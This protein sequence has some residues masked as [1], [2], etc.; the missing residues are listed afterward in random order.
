MLNDSSVF[1]L[2]MDADQMKLLMNF[3]KPPVAGASGIIF[4]GL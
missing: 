1:D 3:N 4:A 2:L